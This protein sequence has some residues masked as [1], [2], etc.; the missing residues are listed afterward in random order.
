MRLVFVHAGCA[1]FET[2]T[3]A[4]LPRESDLSVHTG[5]LTA[6]CLVV[7]CTIEEGDTTD[8][9]RVTDAACAE[10]VETTTRLGVDHVLLY[11]TPHLSA[12]PAADAPVSDLVGGI[13]GAVRATLDE[14]TGPEEWTVQWVPADE[15]TTF[16][17]AAKGHPHARRS[18]RVTPTTP[19]G[20]QAER[21]WMVTFPDGATHTVAEVTDGP[22]AGVGPPL[23]PL[24]D[25][26]ARSET[27]GLGL[28]ADE[29]SEPT[30]SRQTGSGQAVRRQF[31]G[32]VLVEHARERAITTGAV[33]V[34]AGGPPR[35]T[36]A[37]RPRSGL[38]HELDPL[39]AATPAAG[40]Q[41]HRSYR[42]AA[43]GSKN[44]AQRT[45]VT[46]ELWALTADRAQARAELDRHATVHREL[47]GA[48]GLETAPLLRV[49]EQTWTT[50]RAWVDSLVTTLGEPVL[51]ERRAQTDGLWD[52]TLGFV[53]R[54]AASPVQTGAVGVC[55][56]G[57]GATESGP[58][59]VATGSGP[60]VCTAMVSAAERA[61]AATLAV[62]RDRD[63]PR[64]PAWLAP[65][66]VRLV[67]TDPGE[68]TGV[69][70]E[71]ADELEVGRG[72]RV[73]VDDRSLSVGE[74]LDSTDTALS[75][76]VAVVGRPEASGDPLRVTDR[77][78]RT[79]RELTPAALRERVEAELDDRPRKPRYLPR[80]VSEQPP[81]DR[82]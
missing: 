23:G 69:C 47:T 36:T 19:T 56:D 68:Y 63:P 1:R 81:L 39:V 8:T 44:A 46:P 11:P 51:A 73:D 21:T 50:H 35:H 7:F 58:G 13:A 20:H 12:T 79:E 80:L 72:V 27:A 22:A 32:D 37:H 31:L 57:L 62:A 40:D 53:T 76:Y 25:R 82:E 70:Q 29:Q 2:G 71:I 42:R 78:T 26:V 30:W 45:R 67:P 38:P 66:Q 33:A 65:T 59:R 6:P 15:Q 18:T 24:L 60:V 74:R 34:G 10:T 28:T 77:A 5:E 3:A 54:T 14:R 9:E 48:L 4:R 55:L 75:P 61:V 64:L 17:V 52:L 43:T 16:E 41:P 49:R